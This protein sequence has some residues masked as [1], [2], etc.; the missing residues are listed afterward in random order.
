MNFKAYSTVLVA[1]LI[2]TASILM[3]LSADNEDEPIPSKIRHKDGMKMVYIPAGTFIMG[4]ET[5]DLDG[6]EDWLKIPP[7]EV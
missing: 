3:A 6:T 4:D 1:F 5:G 7:H 2:M